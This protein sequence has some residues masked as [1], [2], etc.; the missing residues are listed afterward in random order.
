MFPNVTWFNPPYS[1]N[2]E[3]NVAKYF[4]NLIDKHFPINH[5]FR[6]L[7]NRKNLKVSY[8]CMRSMKSVVASHNK[9]ILC[10]K[11][12]SDPKN[13]CNCRNPEECPLDGNCLSENTLYAGIVSSDLRGY[14][15]KKYVGISAPPWKQ[16]YENHK[17]SFNKREYAK[18]KIA[19]E[20]WKVKDGGGNPNIEWHILGHA[21]AYTPEAK[22]CNL[23]LMEKLYIAEN[24]ER[25]IN[26]RDELISKCRHQNKF[27][28]KPR[29]RKKEK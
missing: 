12:E 19:K 25:L 10:K 14:G 4:L 2:V 26:K 8:S 6:K 23:C 28:L 15:T 3:T 27:I 5:K 21:A 29:K 11:P 22:K 20:V 18:C 16:R 9:N 7:F 24:H 17:T 1:K 13:A